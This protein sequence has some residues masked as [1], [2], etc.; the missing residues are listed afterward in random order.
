VFVGSRENRVGI[1][2]AILYTQVNDEGGKRVESSAASFS[3]IIQRSSTLSSI[4]RD[5]VDISEQ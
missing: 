4:T 1:N 3:S 5:N 2:Q